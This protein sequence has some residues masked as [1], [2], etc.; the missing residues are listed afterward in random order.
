MYGAYMVHVWCIFRILYSANCLQCTIVGKGN[1]DAVSKAEK[2]AVIKASFDSR[3][4]TGTRKLVTMGASQ[5]TSNPLIK[6]SV[7]TET[8]VN[9]INKDKP[10]WLGL[11]FLV[12]RQCMVFV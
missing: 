9:D 4:K 2:A 12:P 7:D 5:L 11:S 8:A 3:S 10:P 1:K 6:T